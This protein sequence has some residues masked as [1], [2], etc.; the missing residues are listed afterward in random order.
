MSA[1]ERAQPDG[2]DEEGRQSE[3]EPHAFELG[4]DGPKVLVVGIDG[5]ETS[6]RA[7]SYAIGLARRQRS[8][9]V[10]LYV[11]AVSGA[12]NVAAGSAA[13]MATTHD[14][15]ARDFAR[16]IRAYMNELGKRDWEFRTVRGDVFGELARTADD[17][18]ADGV[19]VG[20]STQAGH[21]IAGSVAVRL[22]RAGRWPVTVVP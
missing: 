9:I 6:L 7:A 21:R 18:R 10:F 1:E 12:F 22:V 15:M 4:T 19:L 14:E 17:V 13:L 11:Q 16:R 3:P 2:R 8:R 20:A 5:S